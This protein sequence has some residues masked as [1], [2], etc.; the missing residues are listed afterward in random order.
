[1]FLFIEQPRH[2]NS[3]KSRISCQNYHS[4]AQTNSDPYTFLSPLTASCIPAF[5]E[6]NICQEYISIASAWAY[7]IYMVIEHV[8]KISLKFVPS[9][10]SQK[11]QQLC[12]YVHRSRLWWGRPRRSFQG[13][14]LRTRAL[15][16]R[17]YGRRQSSPSGPAWSLPPSC[18]PRSP[19][20][21]RNRLRP[22]QCSVGHTKIIGYIKMT[23][24]FIWLYTKQTRKRLQSLI[25]EKL[26][27][28]NAWALSSPMI[29][30]F[31]L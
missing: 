7:D 12:G 13:R 27:W 28:E 22:Q 4:L 3:T 15:L 24:F 20:R 29:F 14:L 18:C 19:D 30:L 21:H 6:K 1:M 26:Q 9:P 11:L 17:K 16:C 31:I 23:F 8:Y 5:N 2:H 10:F 25:S